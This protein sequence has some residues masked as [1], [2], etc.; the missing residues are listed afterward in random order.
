MRAAV[1][2]AAHA[3]Y[4]GPLSPIRCPHYAAPITSRSRRRCAR[5][6]LCA[7][8]ERCVPH[9]KLNCR[10]EGEG[11]GGAVDQAAGRRQQVA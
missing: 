11:E 9:L 5:L 6:L 7:A 8:A 1:S 4:H 3:T 2:Y 10:A